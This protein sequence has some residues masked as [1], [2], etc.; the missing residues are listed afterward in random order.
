[1]PHPDFERCARHITADAVREL[2]SEMVDIAS[3]TGGEAQMARHLEGR[4]ARAG[5]ETRLQEVD[6][7][8]PNA[9]G[10]GSCGL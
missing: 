2:L 1:M 5:M 7:G 3:P 4:M 8:R 9:V 6:P 10:V